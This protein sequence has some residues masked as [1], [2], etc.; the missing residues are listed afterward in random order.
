MDTSNSER[1]TLD[2]KCENCN[3]PAHGYDLDG[4]PL[5]R[6]CGVLLEANYPASGRNDAY[7]E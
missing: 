4:V 1:D 2:E 3:E 5:C 7:G 6:T